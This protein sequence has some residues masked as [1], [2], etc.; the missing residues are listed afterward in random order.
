LPGQVNGVLDGL[1]SRKVVFYVTIASSRET[2]DPAALCRE[3]LA[4]VRAAALA[5][6]LAAHRAW[7]MDY[8]Q[9]GLCAVGDDAVEKLYYRSLY[10]EVYWHDYHRSHRLVATAAGLRYR[11]GRHSGWR[12]C[13]LEHP[14]GA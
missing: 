12:V 5:E 9:R 2:D 7:W 3:R 1:K 4:R 14:A 6:V 11:Y 10:L 13:G 8:W